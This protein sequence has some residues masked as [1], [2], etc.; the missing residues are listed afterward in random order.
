MQTE[1]VPVSLAASSMMAAA[2]TVSSR[3]SNCT[4]TTEH[5]YSQT[6]GQDMRRAS[7]GYSQHLQQA[8]TARVYIQH[9]LAASTGNVYSHC[10]Y[11]A[12]TD[13]AESQRMQPAGVGSGYKSFI[14]L[15]SFRIVS[16]RIV[17]Y[18]IVSYRIVSYRIVSYRHPK[19]LTKS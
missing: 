7:T 11:P 2:G 10:L 6:C 5:L 12:S 17:S 4:A 14:Y 1:H 13:S 18:R 15:F 19:N 3:D 8:S 16:Y 9:P